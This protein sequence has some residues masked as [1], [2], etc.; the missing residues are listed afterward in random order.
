M[1]TIIISIVTSLI[2]SLIFWLFFT[3]VPEGIKYKK[4][5]LI[6]EYDICNI[7]S[8]ILFFLQM[9]YDNRGMR[10]SVD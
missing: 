2:S 9:A 4:M 10:P 1:Q 8:N 6:I 3:K 5:R 7:S